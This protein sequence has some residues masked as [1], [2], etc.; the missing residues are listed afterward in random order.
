MIPLEQMIRELPPEVQRS[1]RE[2]VEYL[3]TKYNTPKQGKPSFEWQGA[4]EFLRD[5]YTSVELQTV[6]SSFP[7]AHSSEW[8]SV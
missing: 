8:Q 1:V 7:T 4:L 3:Y 5:Q 6:Q 2:F